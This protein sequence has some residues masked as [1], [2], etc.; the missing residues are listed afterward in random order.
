MRYRLNRQ[1]QDLGYFTLEELHAVGTW[2]HLAFVVTSTTTALYVNGVL[3]TVLTNTLPLPR[4]YIGTGYV[5]ST[6][7]F[8]DFMNGR[9][10]E[11]LLFNRVL[12]SG[13]ISA[14]YAAGSSGLVR[15][16]EFLGIQP[17]GKGHFRLNLRGQTGKGFTI[18]ASPDLTAWASLGGVP[19]SNGFL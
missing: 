13:E 11:I 16:P 18:Y 3:R 8:V 14:I 9:L 7:K 15:S 17:L 12:S 6:S 4:A 10:D 1:G 2:A 19:T 5:S